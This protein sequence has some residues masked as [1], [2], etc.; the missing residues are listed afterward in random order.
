MA[1]AELDRRLGALKKRLSAIR[2]RRSPRRFLPPFAPAELSALEAELGATLP[3]DVRAFALTITRGEEDTGHGTL[4]PLDAAAELL[5][6]DASPAAPFACG[7]DDAAA[8]LGR[9]PKRRRGDVEA[10]DGS[11]AGLLPLRDHG[12]GE[13]DCVVVTGEQRGKMWRW[14][15]AGLAPIHDVE[16]GRAIPVDFLTWVE[17]EL[18]D[19]LRAAPP[20]ISRKAKTIDLSA[21]GLTAI[22]PEVFS[23]AA[24]ERLDLSLNPLGAVP[25]EIGEL[26]ALRALLLQD[27]GLDALPAEIGALRS[28]DRLHLAGNRLTALPDTLGDLRALTRLDLRKNHLAHL[29]PSLSSLSALAELDVSDNRLTALPSLAGLGALRILKLAENPLRLLPD[30]LAGTALEAIDLDALPELDLAQALDALSSVAALRT[31]EISTFRRTL[32]SLRGFTQLT[33]LRITGL[34]LGEVPEEIL[35]LTALESLS[36]ARN[37]LTSLPDALFR[38]PRLR[39]LTLHGNPIDGAY[40]AALRARYPGITIYG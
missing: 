16:K 8:Y 25:A 36:F 2:A 29:P 39:A 30:G 15:E 34:L 35:G 10:L 5:G 6:R 18:S 28:L 32:P 1:P 11:A 9:A 38:L 19:A 40:L 13:Y 17:R 26:T 31:L 20:A 14:W 27:A 4:V 23:A 12:C 22:P 33:T 24:A 37:R 21:Q 3:D 7:D